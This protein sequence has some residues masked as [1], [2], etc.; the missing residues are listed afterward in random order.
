MD[1]TDA[2]TSVDAFEGAPPRPPLGA[3]SL[4]GAVGN[5]SGFHEETFN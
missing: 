4:A 5:G 3:E 1:T 2:A